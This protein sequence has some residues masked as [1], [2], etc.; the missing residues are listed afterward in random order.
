MTSESPRASMVSGRILARNVEWER[1][2]QPGLGPRALPAYSRSLPLVFPIVLSRRLLTV[3]FVALATALARSVAAQSSDSTT[4][5]LR[6]SVVSVG[7]G[8]VLAAQVVV[9]LP[10]GAT[11]GTRTDDSGRFVLR[12]LPAGPATVRV[13]ALGYRSADTTAEVRGGAEV[14]LD[15]RLVAVPRRLGEVRTIA[16]GPERAGFESQPNVGNV[17]VAGPELSRIPALGESDVLRAVALLPGVSAR[18]DYSAGF[19]VRGGESDQ[20]L[21][22]LDGIPIYNPFHLGGLFGTF[23]DEAVGG[24]D[25]QTGG[26][27]AAYG[28]RLSSV[29]DVSSAQEARSGVHGAAEVSLLSSTLTLGGAFPS[30]RGSWNLAA[31]RTYADKVAAAMSSYTFPYHFQDVQFHGAVLVPGGGTLSLTAYAGRDDLYEPPPEEGG[32][33]GPGCERAAPDS[34]SESERFH[35]DWGNRLVGLTLTQPLGARTTLVQRASLSLF[36]TNF[37]VNAGR[38]DAMHFINTVSDLQLSG[39]L[40]SQRGA[41]TLGAG[42]ELSRY[43]IDYDERLGEVF[44]DDVD[45]DPLDPAGYD[46]SRRVVVGEPFELRQRSGA[47]AVYAEDLWRPNARLLLRP[48]L[49]AEW[50]PGARWLGVSPRLSAKYFLTDDFAV[51]AAAGRYAQWLHAVRNEDLPLRIFDL[52]LASDETVPVSTGTHLV[53]GAEKWLSGDR[54]VRVEAYGK[55]YG[56]LPEPPFTIDPRVR[57]EELRYFSGRSYGVDVFL[58]QLE[59]GR[60]GGWV[61][62]GYGVSSRERDGRRYWP[63]QDRRHNANV[64]M[65][66]T[67]GRRWA[68]GARYGLATGNPYTALIGRYDMPI[69]DPLGNDY[70]DADVSGRDASARGDRNAE[71]YPLYQRIDLSVERSY[72]AGRAT[73]RPYLSVVNVTNRR[74]VFA[75]DFDYYADPPTAK[76][77][78]QFPLLPTLGLK[79]EF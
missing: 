67:P 17:T 40:T 59:T 1:E 54:F 34:S 42:Y 48:G 18:N 39:S 26:F 20:N 12:R 61:S 69:Y 53:A 62:Y 65:S 16:Q 77:L 25:L 4:G 41:H 24:I 28:G 7:M 14:V 52:W 70:G 46:P 3:T 55:Q 36:S 71:R 19:N 21:I 73:I 10:G 56:R 51:T 76:A 37:G 9:T 79:V 72:T 45:L 49:R 78:S 6:G 63:A 57:P 38:N 5:V 31:R 8:E 23:I 47:A 44:D 66:W 13:R 60:F 75:Y 11:R 29:L 35:F 58:R 22:L 33:R 15:L 2:Y 32:C 27:S 68:L 43:A 50:V 30:A 64:V 74:N